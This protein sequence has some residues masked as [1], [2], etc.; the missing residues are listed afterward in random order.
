[1]GGFAENVTGLDRAFAAG[2]Q[3]GWHCY[4][5][6]VVVAGPGLERREGDW[7]PIVRVGAFYEFPT[8]GGWVLSPAV[9]YDF[10]EAEDLWIYGLNLGYSW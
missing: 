1:M 9:F 5:E 10:L 7:E 8:G 2:F 3:L 4:R 6:L